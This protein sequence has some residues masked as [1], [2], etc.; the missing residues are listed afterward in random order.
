MARPRGILK[1]TGSIGDVTRYSDKRTGEVIR[2]K[3]GPS[4]E[5]ISTLDSCAVVRQN[6]GNFG[7]ASK[8]GK[9]LRENMKE[10]IQPCGDNRLCGRVLQK[11]TTIIN[12]SEEKI[13]LEKNFKLFG[14]VELNLKKKAD[15][16]F[17]YPIKRTLGNGFVVSFQLYK[18]IFKHATHC[19]IIS[20]L[21]GINTGSGE[22]WNNV[23]NVIGKAELMKD[24]EI[25]H[26]VDDAGVLFH[27][28][29]GIGYVE[30]YGEMRMVGGGGGINFVQE[31]A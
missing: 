6:Y 24:I 2:S 13:L 12:T 31:Q 21:A 14:M 10:V 25:N 26:T 15:N 1:F 19:K 29:C 8:T 5:Q 27:G 11:F 18:D 3:G 17:K 23:Q 7:I 30:E 16:I 22:A 4:K 9:L 28:F 20:V